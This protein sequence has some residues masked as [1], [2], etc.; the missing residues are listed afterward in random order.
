MQNQD[1]F[2][3]AELSPRASNEA[4][5]TGVTGF[6]GGQLA[7]TLLTTSDRKLI[8]PVRAN[9]SEHAAERG[10]ARL[11]ELFGT[12]AID[13]AHRVEWVRSDLEEVQ[14]GWATNRVASVAQ[15]IT[16]VFHCAASVR[17]DLPLDE[18][19]QINVVGTQNVFALAEAA[20]KATG[21]FRR[22]HHVSTA[23]VAG[24]CEGRVAPGFLPSARAKNFRNTY[25][26]TKAEAERWLRARASTSIPVSI[27]RPSIVGGATDTGETDN[28]NVLYVPMKMVARGM[29]PMFTRGGRELVDSVGVDF[30]VEAMAVFAQVDTKPFHCHHLTAGDSAFTVTDLLR[31]TEHRAHLAG[32]EPSHTKFMHPRQWQ[33]VFAGLTLAARAP[34]KFKS[35]RRKGRLAAR[36]ADSFGVYVPYTT[37]DVAYDTTDDHATLAKYGVTMPDGARYLETI[38]DYALAVDFGKRKPDPQ[39]QVLAALA[40]E[41]E[42]VVA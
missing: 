27:H 9:S 28:W 24:R 31:V 10:A 14:L 22:F 41:L 20:D 23:Y 35:I 4:L 39:P 8:C 16:E 1:I 36:A 25:E 33:L 12:S 5:V 19:R 26:Q 11:T 38:I 42:A 18:A 21:Q 37:V 15:R 3:A 13:V 32:F 30:V 40:P 2:D 17:F 6:V 29:L 7:K 34:K